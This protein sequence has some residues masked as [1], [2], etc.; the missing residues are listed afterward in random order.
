MCR[1]GLLL[2]VNNYKAF[3]ATWI[4]TTSDVENEPSVPLYAR[5][6]S[7]PLSI[8]LMY[9]EEHKSN[10]EKTVG[11]EGKEHNCAPTHSRVS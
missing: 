11:A 5:R 6:P 7:L 9:V 4:K 10:R 2:A 3:F 1:D 8:I